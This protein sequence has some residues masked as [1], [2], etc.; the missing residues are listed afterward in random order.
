M[1]LANIISLIKEAIVTPESLWQKESQKSYSLSELIK[2]KIAP[3][4]IAVALM[5]TLLL[6][7]FGYHVPFS[8]VSVH[9]SLWDLLIGFIGS[10]IMT[11]I[12][13]VIFGYIA[14]KLAAILGGKED[15]TAGV[16][17]LFL[18]SI[19]SFAGRAVAAVPFIGVLISLALSIY[20]MVLLYRAPSYFLNL[21]QESRVKFI[22][23]FFVA[24]IF[25]SIGLA[26]TLG[27]LF[28]PSMPQLTH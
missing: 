3:V 21:P 10:V 24:S 25:V 26:M 1:N 22:I 12:G 15:F 20:S 4:V 6:L 2:T 19:P 11:I 5:S 28:A 16:A 14:S 18:I 27:T 8:D 13:I 7:I 9:L 17:M 23:L